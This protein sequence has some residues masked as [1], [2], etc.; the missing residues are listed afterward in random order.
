VTTPEQRELI[1]Q[2]LASVG[3]TSVMFVPLGAG[4]ECL[5][6]LVLTRDDSDPEWTDVEATA[7][8]DIGHD[9][10]RAL[11]NA[12]MFDRERRLVD[13]LQQ[14]D[15]YKGRLIATIS[16]ELKNPLT[17]IVG[18]AEL[19]ASAGLD[20]GS[21]ASV[22]AIERGAAR[23]NRLVEDLLLLAKVGDPNNPLIASPV[24]LVAVVDDVVATLALQAS[25]K[26]IAV[27]FD[28]PARPVVAS[29]ELAELERLCTNLLI[30]AV[31]YTQQ[32]GSVTLA[33]SRDGADAILTCADNGLGISPD[34]QG[35]LF[36]EFFRSTNP[37]ALAVPGTGLG[38]AISHRIVERHGGR[39]E[40]ES[41]LG[42][43]TTFTVRLPAVD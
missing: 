41:A 25:S 19:L 37:A 15:R 24:D 40:V 14:L 21:A 20:P 17:S 22:G 30:N 34:D 1:L 12:R 2:F 36:T 42:K 27:D 31:K 6:N 35:R 7:A 28:R 16:H 11:L 10:G 38:L 13:E 3:I 8:L 29:G 26:E 43:G 33:L 5:G 39:I 32:G 9:L 18:H 4:P 23:L